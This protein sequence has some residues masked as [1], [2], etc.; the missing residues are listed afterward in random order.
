MNESILVKTSYDKK[1]YMIYT[2]NTMIKKNLPIIGIIA[3]ALI[4][5]GIWLTASGNMLGLI[6]V[7]LGLILPGLIYML[8][9]AYIRQLTEITE[10]I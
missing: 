1:D 8:V 5:G 7:I 4:G 10:N 2:N 6:G 3:I 9:A